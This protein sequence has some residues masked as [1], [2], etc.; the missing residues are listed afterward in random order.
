MKVSIDGSIN[1]IGVAM[2][3]NNKLIDADVLRTKNDIY[4]M[5]KIF[6][7]YYSD[8]GIEEI[9]QLEEVF[10]E[11]PDYY[12]K[13]TNKKSM[14]SLWRAIGYIEGI[15]CNVKVTA[16]PVSRWKYAVTGNARSDKEDT[17]ICVKRLY[18]ETVTPP[19]D[20]AQSLL[21]NLYDAIAIG[22]CGLSASKYL[23]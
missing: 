17:M 18:P 3:D 7:D 11:H 2:W 19:E 15:H 13:D 10:I 8:F 16:I 1:N 22:H 9:N 5:S 6:A 20:V 23:Q 12:F 21:H 4:S 14:M